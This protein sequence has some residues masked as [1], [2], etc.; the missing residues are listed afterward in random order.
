MSL[1]DSI[2]A[3]DDAKVAPLDV[4]EWG[5][6]VFIRVLSG[7]DRDRFEAMCQ[8]DPKTGKKGLDNFR[9]RFAVLVLCDE[10]GVRL[11]TDAEA[12]RLGAKSAVALDR[13][14][15]AGM[16][17]NALDAGAVAELEGKSGSGQSFDSGTRSP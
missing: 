1:K 6:S 7:V 9:A 8:P 14:L 2:L 16:R 11:F 17:Q 5:C 13:I 15:A 4:P 3:A 12:D 10:K